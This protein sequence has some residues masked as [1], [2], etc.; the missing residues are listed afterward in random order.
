MLSPPSLHYNSL[1]PIRPLASRPLQPPTQVFRLLVTPSISIRKVDRPC[2]LTVCRSYGLFYWKGEKDYVK[3]D[4]AQ[5]YSG[6][7]TGWTTK[8]RFHA[9]AR[10]FLF[11]VESRSTLERVVSSG[12]K[13]QGREADHSTPPIVDLWLHSSICL[14]GAVLNYIIK[15]RITLLLQ[16][17]YNSTEQKISVET[18]SGEGTIFSLCRNAIYMESHSSWFHANI[19]K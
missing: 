16:L 11:S 6:W 10:G 1:T 2:F 9:G 5:A 8:I 18:F 4:I 19:F 17:I 7:A 15:T 3:F 13:L 12:V 14:H